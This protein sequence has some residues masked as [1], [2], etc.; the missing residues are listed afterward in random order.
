MFS[1]SKLTDTQKLIRKDYLNFL[2]EFEGAIF[3]SD[4]GM[5]TIAF[6]PEFK[7]SRMLRVAFAICN[8][9]ETK[10]RRKVGEYH[11]LEKLFDGQ[12]VLLPDGFDP[13]TLVEAAEGNIWF[14]PDQE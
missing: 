9:N 2:A 14:V 6:M 8:P 11:A 13:Y 5:T 3:S 7:G 12:Y 4:S 1:N 10:I